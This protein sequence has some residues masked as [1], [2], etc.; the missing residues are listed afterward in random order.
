M[1]T[2]KIIVYVLISFFVFSPCVTLKGW[3]MSQP[4]PM[5]MLSSC[6]VLKSVCWDW[7]TYRCCEYYCCDSDDMTTANCYLRFDTPVCWDRNNPFLK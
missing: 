3:T 4:V 6:K 5:K 2:K 1:K 7:G